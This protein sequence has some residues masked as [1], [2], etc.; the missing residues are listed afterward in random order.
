MNY[1]KAWYDSNEKQKQQIESALFTS[2]AGLH[3]KALDEK[4]SGRHVH[5]TT[6]KYLNDHLD[7]F[8]EKAKP[9]L[10]HNEDDNLLGHNFWMSRN[11][12]GSDYWNKYYENGDKLH[13]LSKQYPEVQLYPGIDGMV[14]HYG[15]KEQVPEDVKF[16]KDDEGDDEDTDGDNKVEPKHDG[17]K[18]GTSIKEHNYSVAY[19][20]ALI[21]Y[22]HQDL[23]ELT[24]A[25][26]NNSEQ[27][28]NH[29]NL[30]PYTDYLEELGKFNLAYFIRKSL[31]QGQ[32]KIA[33]K[34]ERRN[35]DAAFNMDLYSP[36]NAE[37]NDIHTIGLRLSNGK[38]YHYFPVDYHTDET[39][40]L[41]SMAHALHD[42][43]IYGLH[44]NPITRQI[45]WSHDNLR[46]FAS[47]E[48]LKEIDDRVRNHDL[49]QPNT[50]LD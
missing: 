49:S 28:G 30:G 7:H 22:N 26:L 32:S 24:P 45:M 27:L 41:I 37:S 19:S 25:F 17:P 13:A 29:S 16:G 18:G 46:P 39:N 8:Y 42:E 10:K 31:A 1:N 5:P 20:K 6:I 15:S 47:E 35:K 44:A 34:P 14:H 2:V 11:G 3:N 40:N 12:L 4:F 23:G 36:K 9:L 33:I 38:Y 21:K 43:G 50:Y 48:N